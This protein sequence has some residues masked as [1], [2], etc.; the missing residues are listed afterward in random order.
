[1]V[2]FSV[3]EGSGTLKL[4]QNICLMFIILKTINSFSALAIRKI[5]F[6]G[7]IWGREFVGEVPPYTNTFVC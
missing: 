6:W 7:V 4:C 5:D 1:M 2:Q 3:S